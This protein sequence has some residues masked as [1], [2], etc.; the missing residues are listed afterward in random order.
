MCIMCLSPYFVDAFVAVVC[1]SV[2]DCS[3]MDHNSCSV[4]VNYRQLSF[5]ALLLLYCSS[6]TSTMIKFLKN[7][8]K[9]IDKWRSA[10]S[11]FCLQNQNKT[12]E[13]IT[14]RANNELNVNEKHRTE[15]NTHTHTNKV[16][17]SELYCSI[18]INCCVPFRYSFF[19]DKKKW[20][21]QQHFSFIMNA[22]YCGG[23]FSGR[24]AQRIAFKCVVELNGDASNWTC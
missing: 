10:V 9:I 17:A 14:W 7:R 13:S 12:P 8:L 16:S 21:K 24:I 18:A 23:R 15:C 3:W 1:N 11:R 20:Q 2:C 4:S 19:N 6:H 22:R 5:D